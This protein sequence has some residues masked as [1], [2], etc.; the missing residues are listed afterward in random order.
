MIQTT[1]LWVPSRALLPI[2][3]RYPVARG[4][5]VAHNWLS[6]FMFLSTFYPSPPVH[7]TSWWPYV[8]VKCMSCLIKPIEGYPNVR[9]SVQYVR[10]SHPPLWGWYDMCCFV[11]LIYAPRSK[12]LPCH[13]ELGIILRIK[14]NHPLPQDRTAHSCFISQFWTVTRWVSVSV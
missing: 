14:R 8:Q 13:V 11:Q 1:A 9:S 3:F 5:S 2:I 6:L 12:I 4:R 7:N 10:I